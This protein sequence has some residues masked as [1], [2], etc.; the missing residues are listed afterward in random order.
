MAG[1][2]PGE[3]QD[4]G[5]APRRNACSL[6]RNPALQARDA[7]IRFL[8]PGVLLG[9][10]RCGHARPAQNGFVT[11]SRTTASSTSTGSSLNQ[12]YQTWERVSVPASN[13]FS[14]LPHPW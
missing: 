12:R 6:A 5:K 7:A 13:R 4:A 11:T 9:L 8:G 14:N 2:A 1:Y 3:F 10:D